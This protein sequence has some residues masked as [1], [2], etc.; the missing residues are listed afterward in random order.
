MIALFLN[1]SGGSSIQIDLIIVMFPVG[2]EAQKLKRLRG[3]RAGALSEV[4][5]LSLCMIG[6]FTSA[7]L[8]CFASFPEFSIRL[9]LF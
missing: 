9:F 3:Q 1:S 5:I 2:H 7:F 6:N 4:K 8:L